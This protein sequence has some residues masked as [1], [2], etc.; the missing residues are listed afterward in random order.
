[1]NIDVFLRPLLPRSDV[2]AAAPWPAYGAP[3]R[4]IARRSRRSARRRIA[5]RGTDNRHFFSC[6]LEGDG[7]A[8]GLPSHSA[9]KTWDCTSSRLASH[10]SGVRDFVGR[11]AN[12]P[13]WERGQAAARR[14]LPPFACGGFASS[15]WSGSETFSRAAVEHGDFARALQPVTSCI[16]GSDRFMR[17]GR[18]S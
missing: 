18:V 15:I 13:S 9:T 6:K 11:S 2:S 12:G 3:R 4:R 1:M 5:G 17:G 16:V 8:G 10:P 7:V 14:A